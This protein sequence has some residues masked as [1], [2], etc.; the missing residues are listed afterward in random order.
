MKEE[1]NAGKK[2]IGSVLFLTRR[3]PSL[4]VDNTDKSLILQSL[5]V[6]VICKLLSL[7][8]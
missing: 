2:T 7:I 5:G 8:L 1:T 6:A 4:V 3:G